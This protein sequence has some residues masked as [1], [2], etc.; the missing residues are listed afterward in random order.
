MI[1][2]CSCCFLFTILWLSA[3]TQNGQIEELRHRLT[4]ATEDTS[5]ALIFSQLSLDYDELNADS[6]IA[7]AQ[8]AI[9]LAQQINF[10]RGEVRGLTSL[11]SEFDTKGD[12][13]QALSLDF[14]ALSIAEE[15]HLTLEKIV[16]L[17]N[18]GD[19]FWDLNDYPRAISTYQQA[20]QIT[21]LSKINLN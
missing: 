21:G 11:G 2:T 8:R 18:I 6:A 4:V 1:K 3:F 10:P 13:P 17:N 12:L 15:N 20:V 9:D 5:R 16:S 19:I 14:R 7:I